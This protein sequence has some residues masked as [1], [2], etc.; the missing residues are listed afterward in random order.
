MSSPH[1]IT[2]LRT[3]GTPRCIYS[4]L[5]TRVSSL[6]L[7][8]GYQLFCSDRTSASQGRSS[9]TPEAKIAAE[10]HT[11]RFRPSHSRHR[12]YLHGAHHFY[13]LDCPRRQTPKLR[14]K[15]APACDTY[16]LHRATTYL[17][18]SPRKTKLTTYIHSFPAPTVCPPAEMTYEAKVALS[19]IRRGPFQQGFTLPNCR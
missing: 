11:I 18:S 1:G 10:L 17:Y 12:H 3:P 13:L 6:N 7:R 14:C 15:K 5:T 8:L 2:H 4:A 16:F 19:G 9:S